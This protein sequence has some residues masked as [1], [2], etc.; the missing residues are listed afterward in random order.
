MD[1]L[2]EFLDAVREHGLA[3]GNMRGL[4]HI[5]IGRRI[6]RPDGAVVSAGVT[7]R[8]LANLLKTMRFDKEL[9]S[10]IGADPEELSPRDRQRYWYSAI[11]LARPDSPEARSQ[12]DRLAA[13]VKS[14]GYVVGPPPSP[15]GRPLPA[16]GPRP[17]TEPEKPK[18]RKK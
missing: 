14:L 4:F 10:E 5:A 9:V 3:A 18:K 12:A 8:E 13:E 15:S 17:Q 7:W 16:P 1:G 6:S 11:T 2:R